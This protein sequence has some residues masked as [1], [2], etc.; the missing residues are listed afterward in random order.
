[1]PALTRCSTGSKFHGVFK[2]KEK[3]QITHRR[4]SQVGTANGDTSFGIPQLCV[5][6][7]TMQRIRMELGVLEK[8]AVANLGSSKSINEDD[9]AKGVG[10]KFELSAAACVEGIQQLC[11][12]IAYKITFHDLC[13]VL[14][15]GL[16]VGEV[17]SARI[18]PFLQ[19]LELCLEIISSTVHDRV[20]TRVITDVMKASFDG[21]LLVLLAGGP[22]RAFSLQDS[23]ILEEDFKF[24][25]DLFWSNGDG[26]PAELIAKHSTTVRGILPLFHMD[27]E[28]LIEQF[29]Q[30]TKEIYGGS[31]KSRLPLPPTTG[32]W[33]PRE[34]S[35]LLRILC[36]RNDEAAA[37]FLKKTYNLPKKLTNLVSSR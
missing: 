2:K 35:T 9:I 37:K 5:R 3:S 19:E 10:F 7:N 11:E 29:T 17:S 34:P 23:V 33:S 28:R 6:I 30:L 1:M 26:L 15:D 18:E 32:Q 4:K 21:F 31:S 36:Y 22:S 25:T 13:N 27:T 24:L 14:W 20:R 12:T 8:R 16:Y